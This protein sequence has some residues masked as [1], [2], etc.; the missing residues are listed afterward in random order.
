M[1]RWLNCFERQFRQSYRGLRG[2]SPGGLFK[3]DFKRRYQKIGD[4]WLSE[5][6]ESETKVR[7]FVATVASPHSEALAAT[8]AEES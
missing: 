3:T 4:F 7:V 5:S 1:H 6:N 2:S 8:V